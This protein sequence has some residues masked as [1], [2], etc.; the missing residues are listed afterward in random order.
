MSFSWTTKRKV[1]RLVGVGVGAGG[2]LLVVLVLTGTIPVFPTWLTLS[3][4]RSVASQGAAVIT[5]TSGSSMWTAPQGVTSV[6]VK[7]VGGGAAGGAYNADGSQAGG[8]S[9]GVIM[10]GSYAVTPGTSYTV[11]VGAGGVAPGGA[12]GTSIF[13]NQTATGGSGI[14]GGSPGGVNGETSGM[15]QPPQGGNNGSGCGEGG[16]GGAGVGQPTNGQNG[17]VEI[18]FAQPSDAWLTAT[19]VAINSGST[20]TL[21]WNSNGMTSCTVSGGLGSGLSGTAQTPVL[22][23]GASPTTNTYTLTCNPGAVQRTATVTVFPG[24][25]TGLR[26]C[27][28]GGTACAD[29][30][31]SVSVLPGTNANL[32]WS[33]KDVN[34]CYLTTGEYQGV[35]TA[36]STAS[37]RFNLASSTSLFR[38]PTAA[39]SA[40]FTLSAW[41]KR[42]NFQTSGHSIFW[43]AGG[44]S[45]DGL[46]FDA[47][48]SLVLIVG[49]TTRI[50]T[51]R[52]FRDPSEWL[53]VVY[54]QGGSL[55]YSATLYVNGIQVGQANLGGAAAN[56]NKAVQHQLGARGSGSYFDGYLHDVNFVDGT[57]VPPGSFAENS[58]GYW[59]PKAYTGSYGT[60][61]FH[62][63]FINGAT[64]GSDTSGRLN[65]W[66]MSSMGF[67]DQVL[68]TPF[69]NFATANALAPNIVYSPV[70]GGLMSRYDIPATVGMP[71]GRWYWEVTA[72]TSGVS[73]GLWGNGQTAMQSIPRG[74]TYGFRY[75]ADF[76]T[77]DYTTDGIAWVNKSAALFGSQNLYFPYVAGGGGGSVAAVYNFGQGGRAGLTYQAGAGGFFAYTPTPGFKALSSQNLPTPSIVPSQYFNVWNYQ[78]NVSSQTVVITDSSALSG[79]N[80]IVPADWNN[81]ANSVEVIGSGGS[82]SGGSTGGSGGGGGAYAKVTNISLVPST[83]VKVFVS[84]NPAQ[85]AYFCDGVL[86]CGSLVGSGVKVGAPG[87]SSAAGT[88]PGQGG[89]A[90][91]AVGAI[92]FS[93]GN[94]AGVL[95]QGGTRYGGGAGGAGGP[96]GAGGAGSVTAS[97]NPGT[98]GTGGNGAGG[99]GGGQGTFDT[100]PGKA[101][102]DILAASPTLTIP[103]GQSI[104]VVGSGGGGAGGNS[105]GEGGAYGGGGGGSVSIFSPPGI[106]KGGII[107]IKYTPTATPRT[108]TP[109]WS[110][111]PDLLWLKN[112]TSAYAHLLY[113]KLRGAAKSIS[114]NTFN[115]ESTNDQDGYVSSAFSTNQFAVTAG[116]NSAGNVNL[117]NNTYYGYFFKRSTPPSVAGFDIVQWSGTGAASRAIPH[118]LGTIPDLILAKRTDLPDY[119]YVWS[120]VFDPAGQFLSLNTPNGYPTLLPAADPNV[121]TNSPFNPVGQSVSSINVTAG[122]N[123]V[124]G[125]VLLLRGDDD[126]NAD[127]FA[128]SSSYGH[129]VYHVPGVHKIVDT[130]LKKFGSG[131]LFLPPNRAFASSDQ[132]WVLSPSVAEYDLVGDFSIDFWVTAESNGPANPQYFITKTSNAGLTDATYDAPWGFLTGPSN[133]LSFKVRLDDGSLQ[134]LNLGSYTPGTNWMHIAVFRSGNTWYGVKDGVLQGTVSSARHIATSSGPLI[135]GSMLNQQIGGRSLYFSGHIDEFRINVATNNS[136]ASTHLTCPSTVVGTICFTPPQSSAVPSSVASPYIAYLFSNRPDFIKVGKYLGDLTGPFVYTGFKPKLLLIKRMTKNADWVLYDSGQN[137]YNTGSSLALYPNLSSGNNAPSGIGAGIDWLHNGF[138]IRTGDGRLNWGGEYYLFFAVADVPFKYSGSPT[139]FVPNNPSGALQNFATTTSAV[140]PIN[141]N[142]DYSLVCRTPA[143]ATAKTVTVT[144]PPC[145]VLVGQGSAPS[146]CTNQCVL[147]SDKPYAGSGVGQ[148]AT[149]SW[150][151]PNPGPSGGS[152]TDGTGSLSGSKQVTTGGAYTLSCPGANGGAASITL[153]NLLGVPTMQQTDSSGNPSSV[154][155]TSGTAGYL[156]W[157]VTNLSAASNDA[158]SITPSLPANS[159]WSGTGTTWNQ[160]GLA[161]STH[162]L[163]ADTTFTLRCTSGR[164][165]FPDAVVTIRAGTPT[166]ASPLRGASSAGGAMSSVV[167]VKKGQ[168]AYLTWNVTGLSANHTCSFSASP[169]N[170]GLPPPWDQSGSSYSSGGVF[171]TGPINQPTRFTLTCNSGSS[172]VV[173]GSLTIGLLP[174]FSEQ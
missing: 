33:A 9:G 158:C 1:K 122:L 140:G 89:R 22:T 152:A 116:G 4:G 47:N 96:N 163:S 112:A 164:G 126:A 80:W 166:F 147:A 46:G 81:A 106:G 66:S 130:A 52:Y 115:P 99:A 42:S 145:Q 86:N 63:D 141:Q 128:D 124:A 162:P 93:G 57:V 43:S 111:V 35:L 20:A 40:I 3:L 2:L 139:P 170:S 169:S 18:T 97:F 21:S 95:Q 37:A 114:S 68:D 17:C 108:I 70:G 91:S 142:T 157:S 31:G 10:L 132:G 60:N 105:A 100:L 125:D 82:G 121:I 161:Q 129:Y 56:F 144:L 14:V 131:S 67:Q 24:A 75:D 123:K 7:I 45:G 53:H 16:D 127:V 74:A 85:D 103:S 172:T 19:P 159:S 32:S 25:G 137:P 151:C 29:D 135:F 72:Y 62:L 41:V 168:P 48:G 165:Y 78:G 28:S 104:T 71:R 15:G 174:G 36:T 76:G 136:A 44:G 38:T 65:N 118:N 133:T 88:T 58:T 34:F 11:A 146:S 27:D 83:A 98:G 87:G 101:G 69:N 84:P 107:V 61:G 49:N 119:W 120:S 148:A 173:S 54:T 55:F 154:S 155:V 138:R 156:T 113:D 90:E 94:G 150:C 171:A 167:R 117:S 6:S 109:N 30:G 51:T 149:L 13:A 92:K 110:M 59:R 160:T 39:G 134:T 8:G 64:L 50:A 5:Y 153:S 77:F 73:A 102:S 26:V 12:G 23:T 79:S 143:G